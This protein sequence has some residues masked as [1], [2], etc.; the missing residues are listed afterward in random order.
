MT[1]MIHKNSDRP[2]LSFV[3]HGRN[4]NFMGDF[5]WRLGTTINIISRS[6]KKLERLKDIEIIVVDWNSENPL[7]K[8]VQLVP[9]AKEITKFI[10]VPLEVAVPAQKDTHYPDSIVA[11]TGLRRANGEFICQTGSDVLF[12]TSTLNSLY[13]ERRA[14]KEPWCIQD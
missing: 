8:V 5:L 6:A 14:K 7:H 2:I 13:K 9:E 10:P 12:T 3:M 1:D 4:D 11:N